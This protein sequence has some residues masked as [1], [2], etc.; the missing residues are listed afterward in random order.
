MTVA[1]VRALGAAILLAVSFGASAAVM[2]RFDK[3]EETLKIRPEQKEQFDVAV[4]ATQRALLSVALTAMQ[5]KER[6]ARELSKPWPDLRAFADAHEALIEQ[7]RP[8]FKAAG[9]E[10]QKLYALL[11]DEQVEIAKSFLRENLSALF[12]R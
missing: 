8:L 10:W 5:L 7:N 4:G 12:F 9:E 6:L 1:F 3:L 2:P 11:D